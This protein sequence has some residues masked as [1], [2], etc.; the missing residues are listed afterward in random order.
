M[1]LTM[2][3]NGQQMDQIL[4]VTGLDR[5]SGEMKNTY[6][7]YQLRHG[8]RFQR[9][10]FDVR[11]VK[12]DFVMLKDV[13][14]KVNALKQIVMQAPL[15]VVFSDE[16][17]RY[18]EGYLDGTLS[19][20]QVTRT[21]LKGSFTLLMVRPF[22]VSLTEKTVRLE[23]NKLTFRNMGSAPVAPRFEF[24]APANIEMFA[25]VHPSGAKWQIGQ[26][27]QGVV[28]KAGERVSID[29]ADGAVL[30]GGNRRI[31]PL[32]TSQRFDI[33]VGSVEIGV[34]VDNRSTLPDVRGYYR[35]VYV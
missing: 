35:E 22:A 20:D 27:N 13:A 9:R 23:K 21:Y 4:L 6:A 5:S 18:Y 8:G 15:R 17:D 16:G 19:L 31:Y 32:L 30:I 3:I 10:R 11:K 12:I 26:S 14:S 25:L 2:T 34:A 28:I 7:T 1:M 33:E 24:V 29:M